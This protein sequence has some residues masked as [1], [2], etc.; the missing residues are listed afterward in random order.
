MKSVHHHNF[1]ILG[2]QLLKSETGLSHNYIHK[3]ALHIQI[4]GYVRNRSD[5]TVIWGCAE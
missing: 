2:L 3:K 1:E 5:E 4:G